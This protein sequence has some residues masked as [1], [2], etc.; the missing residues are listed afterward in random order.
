MT[1]RT[2]KKHRLLSGVAPVALAAAL[3]FQAVTF[4]PS[5]AA[6]ETPTWAPTASERLI[7]LP[8]VYLKKTIDRD[9]QSSGLAEAIRTR[10]NDLALTQ[11]AIVEIQDALAMAEGEVRIELMHQLLAQKQTFVQL[12]GARI[13]LQR[14]EAET[15]VKLYQRLLDKIRADEAAM[16]PARQ[17]LIDAQ[18]LARDR[19]ESAI[20]DVDMD[21]FGSGAEMS[22]YSE[23]YA[24][25]RAAIEALAA[26]IA[27]HPMNSMPVFDGEEMDRRTY[28]ERLVQD[29]Q[30]T[31][32]LL[33]QEEELLGYMGKLV[34]LDAMALYE[35]I[36][37]AQAEEL[38]IDP[39]ESGV[40]VSDAARLFLN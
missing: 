1:Q 31:V 29:S 34:A 32:A 13:D 22:R 4:T 35:E 27:A 6:T 12:L 20:G 17:E 5:Y 40:E 21:V 36:A 16:T 15:R 23:K 8:T 18:E 10:T 30:T 19:F 2:Q 28:L 33:D 37:D 7:R 3:I 26:Q 24:E 14:R 11:Q 38:G 25:N 9:F 39:E